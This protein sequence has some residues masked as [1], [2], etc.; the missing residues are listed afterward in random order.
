MNRIDIRNHA[1]QQFGT[2][3]NGR[4]VTFRFRYNVSSDRWTFDLSIDD[5][6]VLHGRKVVSGTDLLKPFRR[7][8]RERLNFEIGYLVGVPVTRGAEPD[9]EALP[10]GEFMILHLDEAEAKEFGLYELAYK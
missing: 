3:I 9:R 10:S 4:R 5:L 7:T 6:P 2:I 1:D 8:F